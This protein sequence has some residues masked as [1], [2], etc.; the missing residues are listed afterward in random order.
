MAYRELAPPPEI[1]EH[2][3]CLWVR[4]PQ[5]AARLH[6]IVPDACADI[7]WVTGRR[8][9]VA[10][11]ATGPFMSTIP[12]G[13][14]A[15]GIRFRVGAAGSA[16]GVSA[17]ELL[18]GS[19]ALD[20]VWGATGA[21]LAERL[22][23]APHAEAAAAVLARAVARRL[24]PPHAID[25]I[26]RAAAIGV[27][28]PRTPVE[29]LGASL[30]IGERQLRRRFGDAVGYGPK[31]L[32]RVLRFQR[33]LALA[34]PSPA[35]AGRVGREPPDLA[36]LAF[37]AGYA[38]QAHLTRECRRLAGLPPAALLAT[39]AGPSGERSAALAPDLGILAA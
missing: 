17:R 24:P 1:Q 37:E 15:V 7:V 39:G 14:S 19:F 10:G 32:Q 20:E 12:A 9:R 18:D 34:Q 13:G 35:R 31:T 11:P 6:R 21:E 30:G 3:A 36:R 33:F 16:L 26:V 8:V 4:D 38:D 2:V 27:A 22:D 5:P 29:A 28:R 23:A 25:P